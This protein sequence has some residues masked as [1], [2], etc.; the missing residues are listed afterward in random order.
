[1]KQRASAIVED[2]HSKHNNEVEHF[3]EEHPSKMR[4]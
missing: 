2:L 4:Q 1:L 3:C